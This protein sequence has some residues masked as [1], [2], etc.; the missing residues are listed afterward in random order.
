MAPHLHRIS[1]VVCV[2]LDLESSA[3][4]R[5]SPL[6]PAVSLPYNKLEVGDGRLASEP[7]SS[8]IVYF[9]HVDRF[10]YQAQRGGFQY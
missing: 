6:F 9:I 2:S 8:V 1:D 4:R 7:T 10:V 5:Y 3:Q